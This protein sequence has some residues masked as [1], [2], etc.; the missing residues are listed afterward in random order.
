MVSEVGDCTRCSV[1][2]PINPRESKNTGRSN[3]VKKNFVQNIRIRSRRVVLQR[4]PN[5][6]RRLCNN[7][8][9]HLYK[10]NTPTSPIARAAPY[11]TT[12]FPAAAFVVAAGAAD[13]VADPVWLLDAVPVTPEVAPV[14]SEDGT[15]E[16]RLVTVTPAAAQR[17]WTAGAMPRKC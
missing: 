3:R 1:S 12:P 4:L 10:A 15:T 17:V 13:P 16:G 5:S 14:A 7:I 2:V 11:P 9:Y 6:Y 8:L